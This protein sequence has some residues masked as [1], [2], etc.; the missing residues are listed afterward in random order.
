MFSPFLW[1]PLR[2]TQILTHI[3]MNYVSGGKIPLVFEYGKHEK[4]GMSVH[5]ADKLCRVVGTHMPLLFVDRGGTRPLPSAE[6]LA[7]F[8]VVL[9][10]TD[11]LKNEWSRG[12]FQNELRR[13]ELETSETR[14]DYVLSYDS[15]E[16]SCPL[17]KV[18]WLRL[19]VD[20]GHSMGKGQL[21]S[22]IQFASWITAQRRWA[23]TGTPTKQ[24]NSEL[25]QI[26]GLLA[27]LQHDFFGLHKDGATNWRSGITRP[28]SEGAMSAFFRLRGILSLLMKRH[29]KLDIAELPPPRFQRSLV[30][31]SFVEGTYVLGNRSKGFRRTHS[32]YLIRI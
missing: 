25:N 13:A 30:P 28:W 5:K 1:V 12:S 26:K 6:F 2:K 21:S 11:R 9:T 18:N 32:L 29:T 23:M 17:L 27:F 14:P 8:R 24:S 7:M 16:E 31:M 4:D 3:D 10:S 19:V 22:T 15:P 20:E